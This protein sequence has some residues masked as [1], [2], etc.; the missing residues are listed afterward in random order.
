[1]FQRILVANRGEIALRVIR[2]CR[3]MGLRSVAVHSTA[4]ADSLHVRFADEKVCIGPPPAQDGGSADQAT[5][6]ENEP[7]DGIS[8]ADLDEYLRKREEQQ[9]REAE[10]QIHQAIAGSPD[11]QGLA[12]SLIIDDTPEGLRIQIIDQ[13]GLPMFPR[14][15]SEMYPHT[16]SMLEMVAQVVKK[17]PQA[18]DI[19][20]HTDATRYQG[21]RD[22]SNWELSADR[23]N[24]ARRALVQFG[25]PE[26]RVARVVGKAATEPLVVSDPE[27][28]GNRRLSLVMLRRTGAGTPAAAATPANGARSGASFVR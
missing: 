18:I 21:G 22:Y 15:E 7:P 2:A 26:Q 5:S 6:A 16:R 13:A 12:N 20:G 8:D 1:M 10:K 23:A 4:D 27:A 28:P 3:E 25:V 19:T 17:M 24:A 14:G 9:F 11:L